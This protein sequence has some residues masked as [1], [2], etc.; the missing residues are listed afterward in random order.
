MILSVSKPILTGVAI[1]WWGAP[2]VEVAAGEGKVATARG[3][4]AAVAVDV[5]PAGEPPTNARTEP[6][7]NMAGEGRTKVTPDDSCCVMSRGADSLALVVSVVAVW[8]CLN[9]APGCPGTTVTSA[10]GL[11]PPALAI[12]TTCTQSQKLLSQSLCNDC[13]S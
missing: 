2:D 1:S 5:A 11:N 12:V 3:I 6:F 4:R 7:P 8:G 10:P 13:S 9:A